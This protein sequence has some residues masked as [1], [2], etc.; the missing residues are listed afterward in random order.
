[1]KKLYILVS[2]IIL[3]TLSSTIL[4][5]SPY[6]KEG[7]LHGIIGMGLFFRNEPIKTID[8]QVLALPRLIIRQN[9]FFIDGLELGYR[10]I[11]GVNGYI[12]LFFSPHLEGFKASD[13]LF[14]EGMSERKFSLDG[15][16]STLWRHGTVEVNFS[17]TT[18]I[19]NKSR[20]KEIIFSIGNAYVLTGKMALFI[21][22]V[23]LKWKNDEL[24]NY[25]YGVETV[26]ERPDRPAFQGEATVNY[27]IAFNSTYSLGKRSILFMDFEYEH[28]GNDISDSPLVD[29]EQV[30]NLFLGYGWQF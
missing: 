16:I 18:D 20:G 8:D 7:D 4:A 29:G 5:S 30:F 15:G 9:N 10:A 2:A 1:M 24:V 11:E 28:F 6:Q 26:E 3:I 21:P 25:Y 17:A 13:N 19:L 22:R 14:L 23:G 12:N 27:I